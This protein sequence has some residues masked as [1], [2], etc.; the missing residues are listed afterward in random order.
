MLI[1]L[2][3][4]LILIQIKEWWTKW[5]HSWKLPKHIL[6]ECIQVIHNQRITTQTHKNNNNTT[7]SSHNNLN[8]NP[9]KWEEEDSVDRAIS[10][11]NLLKDFNNHNNINNNFNNHLISNHRNH[12]NSN[13]NSSNSIIWED[14]INSDNN[15]ANTKQDILDNNKDNNNLNNQIQTAIF[16]NSNFQWTTCIFYHHKRLT[17]PHH[18]LYLNRITQI[19]LNN[20]NQ[21]ITCSLANK[22]LVDNNNLN[23]HNHKF[24]VENQE[25]NCQVISK[26]QSCIKISKCQIKCNL[27]VEWAWE[28]VWCNTEAK[29]IFLQE[30]KD[31][32]LD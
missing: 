32:K 28:W 12:F 9:N 23:N 26:W 7:N 20:H 17:F 1:K 10:W 30:C 11:F 31:W 21:E 25:D 8:N 15:Q 19:Y 13:L 3:Q 24:L 5:V 2:Q 16:L 14:K 6:A 22:D 18:N 29:I 4:N 27:V